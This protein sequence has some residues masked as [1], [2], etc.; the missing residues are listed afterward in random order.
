MARQ[1]RR[2]L[3]RTAAATALAIASLTALAEEVTGKVVWIDAK[4]A[5]LLLEC[6]EKGCSAIPNAK[7]GETY[8][9]V[10]PSP[11]HAQ[12][13]AL[14]EGETVKLVY[15]DGKDRGYVITSVSK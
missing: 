4:N 3:A 14:K 10:I 8:T 9:F 11:L 5:S 6:P 15:E 7:P 12:V 2:A 13:I 1:Y